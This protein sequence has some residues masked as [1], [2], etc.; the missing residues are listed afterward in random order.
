MDIYPFFT[1]GGKYFYKFTCCISYQIYAAYALNEFFN[2]STF[3]ILLTRFLFR[4]WLM[5]ESEK[6]DKSKISHNDECLFKIKI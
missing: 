5:F 4:K 3:E 1:N 6:S 2:E